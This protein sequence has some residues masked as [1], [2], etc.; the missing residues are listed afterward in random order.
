MSGSGCKCCAIEKQANER[1]IT[2]EE[3]IERARKIHGDKY[4]YS[5]VEYINITTPIIIICPKHKPFKQTPEN[6]LQGQGCIFCGESKGERKVRFFL[7]NYNINYEKE[8]RFDDCK[9]KK[10]LPFDFYL[11][12]YNLCIEYDGEQHFTPKTFGGKISKEKLYKQFKLCQKR[13]AIKNN[14]CKQKGI[15]LLRI[16]YNE[17]V[18]EKLAEYFQNHEIIKEQSVFDL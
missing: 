11:P 9:Y 4:D 13:D 2:F 10:S 5:K 14:Y 6:H 1:K 16:K 7:K 8:K 18:E 3:F 15:N 12:Q 17:N